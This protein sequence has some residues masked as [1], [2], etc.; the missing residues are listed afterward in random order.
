MKLP[1]LF[2]ISLLIF[3]S[4]CTRPQM[5]EPSLEPRFITAK[6]PPIG[7]KKDQEYQ[8][9]YLIVP[10]NRTDPQSKSIQL[11][12]YIFKSRNPNPKADPIIYTVGGPGY[13]TMTSAPYMNYYSY[14]DDR[15]FILFEQRGTLYSKP[16]LDC[17]EWS[18][19]ISI[20]NSPNFAKAKKDSILKVAAS[21][22]RDRLIAK[23]IDLNGY[24]TQEI[25]ADI[26]DLRKVLGL[27]SYNLLTIS[28]STKIAQVL[29]RDYP[30]GIRSVVMDGAL[31]LA[32]KYDEESNFN[33]IQG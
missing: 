33:L 21:E 23:G 15:D 3:I 9:G 13:T 5:L 20:T 1:I 19:A 10:E 32:S 14:L 29:M 18:K 17:P 22:C 27:K 16:H 30:E 26:A 24:H 25:A 28:Y 6:M 7:I 8:F 31:P 2:S 12:V 11:P 4:G